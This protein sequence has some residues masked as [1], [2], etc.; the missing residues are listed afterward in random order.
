MNFHIFEGDLL[1]GGVGDDVYL[2]ALGFEV[3]AVDAE[4]AEEFVFLRLDTQLAIAKDQVVVIVY[5]YS[6]VGVHWLKELLLCKRKQDA[7]SVRNHLGVDPS[8]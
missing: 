1:L 3:A 8:L 4:V 7:V 5:Y 6:L 2:H